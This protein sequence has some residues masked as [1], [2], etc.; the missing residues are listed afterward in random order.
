MPT[1]TI[2][3]GCSK[4]ALNSKGLRLVLGLAQ[5][6][7]GALQ[8]SPEFKGIKTISTGAAAL[9]SALQASPEFKGIKTSYTGYQLLRR[10][11]SQP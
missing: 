1:D 2:I 8:A 9:L 6:R 4:P 10:A 3:P 7:Q 5:G 11:P